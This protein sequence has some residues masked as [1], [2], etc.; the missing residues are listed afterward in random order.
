SSPSVSICRCTPLTRR[1][2]R[3]GSMSRLRQAWPIARA[4]LS[5]SNGSR[6]A[7]FLIT[8]RS[9]SWTRSKVVK[10]AP[11]ASHWRRRRIAAPSSL[12]RLSLTWLSSCAQKGQRISSSPLQGRGGSREAAEGEGE[13]AASTRWPPPPPPP[14]PGGGGGGKKGRG[15]GNTTTRPP[16]PPPSPAA[17]SA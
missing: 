10:R 5:R 2:I 14:P 1:S 8:V 15:G 3:A 9:R 13:A 11:Q 12:G 4:S 17:C 6:L 16:P 7:S